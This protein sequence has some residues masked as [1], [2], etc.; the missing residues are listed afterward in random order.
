MHR[1][2]MG[3]GGGGGWGRERRMNMRKNTNGIHLPHVNRQCF[4]DP[5]R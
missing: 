4:W 3:G 2:E 1:S 5:T